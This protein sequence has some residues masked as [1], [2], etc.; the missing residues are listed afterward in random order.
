M[1]EDNF[2][3]FDPYPVSQLAD[4]NN[5]FDSNNLTT[6]IAE[7]NSFSY[8]QIFGSAKQIKFPTEIF[9]HDQTI[10]SRRND[11][12]DDWNELLCL[13]D[14]IVSFMTTQINSKFEQHYS[15]FSEINIMPP[16]SHIKAH[17]D[18][19]EGV[20]KN[21]RM[22]LVL[23]TNSCVKFLVEGKNKMLPQGTC[24]VFDNSKKHEVIN[25]HLSKSRTHLV[26]DFKSI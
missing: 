3:M 17:Y 26:I 15:L 21:Y 25:S 13:L 10:T 4:I 7:S 11:L 22:H 24:F 5:F 12:S 6:F 20:G 8:R 18:Q 16:G 14:P 19:H 9:V 23:S 2:I 1:F